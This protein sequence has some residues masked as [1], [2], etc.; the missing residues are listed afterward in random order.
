MVHETVRYATE[1]QTNNKDEFLLQG[2]IGQRCVASVLVEDT[3]SD[4]FLDTGSQV[5]TV[6]ETFYLTNLSL[7][8]IQPM[9]VLFEVEGAGGQN[10]PCLGYITFPCTVTS[11]EEELSLLLLVPDCH[12][13]SKVP[14]L[15]GTNILD[16]LNQQGVER[17]GAKFI[18][19]SG[20]SSDYALLFQHVAQLYESG[21]K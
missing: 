11:A 4:S 18:Q 15:I 21:R 13:N 8:P 17:K 12:F 6:S 2:L 16:C 1:T 7:I 19:K 3:L 9:N 5:T 20:G 14:L 10:V